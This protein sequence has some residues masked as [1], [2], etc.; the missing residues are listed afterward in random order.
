MGI[1]YSTCT[2]KSEENLM[3]Y[4]LAPYTRAAWVI[5]YGGVGCCNSLPPIKLPK[6]PR[7]GRLDSLMIVDGG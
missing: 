4:L 1:C 2:G 3:G 5:G 6:R 7:T